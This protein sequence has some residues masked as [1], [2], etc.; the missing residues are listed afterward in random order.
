[1]GGIQKCFMWALSAERAR[2]V[3][4]N[5]GDSRKEQGCTIFGSAKDALAKHQQI[6]ERGLP[7]ARSVDNDCHVPKLIHT[8]A[9]ATFV[10]ELDSD[11]SG[12]LWYSH[13]LP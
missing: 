13:R 5:F 4:K 7:T 2:R 12:A 1:M 10:T 8:T 11:H 6:K 3:C 9:E